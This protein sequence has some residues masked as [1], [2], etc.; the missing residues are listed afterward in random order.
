MRPR[1]VYHASLLVALSLVLGTAAFS[2]DGQIHIAEGSEPI[3]GQYLVTFV[4]GNEIA[5][6]ARNAAATHGGRLE[7][8]FPSVGVAMFKMNEHQARGLAHNPNVQFVEQDSLGSIAEK[9]TQ[10]GPP[11]WGLDRVDEPTLPMDGRYAYCHSGKGVNIYVVDTGLYGHSDFDGRA[12]LGINCTTESNSDLNGHGTHVAGT[13]AGTEYGVAKDAKVIGVK[14]CT[15]GGS[16]AVSDAVCGIDF[17]KQQ[18]QA[19]PSTPSVANM[20]LRW[21]G[22]STTIDNAVSSA[23]S[24]G[25]FFAVAAGNDNATDACTVSPA[26]VSTA[27]TVGAT[28]SSDARASYSNIGSCLDIFAPGS[29]ILSLGTS[30]STATSTKSG[31]SMASPHVAGAAALILSEDSHLTP[32]QVDSRLDSRATSGVLSSIG[33]GSPNR[34]L[35]A[36]SCTDTCSLV[37]LVPTLTG[38]STKVTTSGVY[39]SSYPGWLAFDNSSSSWLSETFETPAWIAYDFG[40]STY[41]SHYTITNTN[42][43]LVSRAPKDF[44]L[45]GWNGSSWVT[46]DN[47][48]NQTNWIS[49]LQRTYNVATPGSY[50]KYRL[51]ITDD[52][53][54]RTG[55]VVISIGNLELLGCEQ[56]PLIPPSA[57]FTASPTSGNA[58]LGVSLNASCSSDSDG[59]ITSYTWDMGDGTV[60]TG[61]STF[62]TF[63]T[64]GLYTVRLT[65]RDNDSQTASTTR[66]INVCD[67]SGGGN[68]PLSTIGGDGIIRECLVIAQ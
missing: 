6:A 19:S 61:S 38:S 65:V 8:V 28:T 42:G 46:V 11:S 1:I 50:S 22:G 54:S 49:G 37:D 44:K 48:T 14:V 58:P 21:W 23:I 29:S 40:T 13:A 45:Q 7:R 32:A 31:T 2:G 55:V 60:R 5:E 62:H 64:P 12:L 24:A 51:Y 4:P 39:S 15:A 56:P 33:S 67:P 16:C 26:R 63:Y 53:D 57:C 30:S 43:S 59:S 9:G 3:E 25:V 66:S 20:S 36:K 68:E 10:Y 41:I 18:K 27:Y 52:N 17:I 35:N 34:L 47:R